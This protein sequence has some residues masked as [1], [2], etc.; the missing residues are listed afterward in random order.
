MQRLLGL[1]FMLLCLLQALPVAS[2]RVLSGTVYSNTKEPLIGAAIVVKERKSSGTT[3]DANG[4]YSLKLPDG[5]SHMI[6]VS[7][8][9]YVTEELKVEGNVYKKDFTLEE[10][11]IGLETVVVTGTRTPKRL[12]DVPVITRVIT[13]EDIKKTDATNVV[14]VLEMELPAIETSY[15][16]DMQPS[17]NI[18]GFSGNS[19]LFL[20]DGERLA[21]ETMND[22]D[23]SRLGMDGIERVEI[24]R[25][26]SSSIYGSNAVG[27]VVNLITRTATEPWTANL[28]VRYGAYDNQ[29]YGGTFSFNAGKFNNYFNV[30]H[31]RSGRIDYFNPETDGDKGS[32]SSMDPFHSWNFKDKLS[33]KANNKLKF[34]A[35]IGYFYRER[36]RSSTEN[37]R[38]RSFSGGLK[39]VYSPTANDY[40]EVSYAFDQYDK[41]DYDRI[42]SLDIRDYSNVQHSFRGVYSHVFRQKHTLTLG[43]DYMRDYLSSYM[44]SDDKVYEQFTVD[45]FAQFDWNPIKHFNAVVSARYD[46][47]SESKARNFSPQVNLMYKQGNCSLRG[48]YAVGFRAPTLKEMYST[49]NMGSIWNIYG[50]KDLKPEKSHNFSLSAE[51]MKS[52]YNVTLVAYY[53]IVSNRIDVLWDDALDNGKGA[54]KYN[55]T[56]KMKIAGINL[57]TS[58][59]YPCGFEIHLAYAY[60]HQSDKY[61]QYVSIARPHSATARFNYGKDWKNYGFNVSLSGKVLSE[62]TTQEYN[63]QTD[64]SLGTYELK[65][66]AYTLWKLNVTQ[67]FWKGFNLSMTVDNLFNYKP[68]YYYFNSP[69]TTGTTFL[70]GLSMDI[71]KIF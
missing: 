1:S 7:Y 16:M 65:Y 56:D 20:V 46:Y 5:D 61:N 21:G 15:S 49:F 3:T 43:G 35:N 66:P 70:V 22:V 44:F 10:D 63:S 62:I 52:R 17:L 12:K 33:F 37:N 60:T 6:Q 67:S 50:N 47:Y 26:A 39:G 55:N 27:G 14:D 41:S 29:R 18:Q 51:Y 19:V 11:A 4:N 34:T 23:F 59:K 48:A 9:G 40:L 45:A 36:E 69:Y 53:N 25:G 68:S 32:Y 57:D 71:D 54:M 2:Q 28:N 8:I 31:L 38:Y 58:A 64:P 42:K 24:V 30:Q 13:I